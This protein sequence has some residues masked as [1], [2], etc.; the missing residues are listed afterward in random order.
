M[1]ACV[2]VRVFMERD[3]CDCEAERERE[4][5]TSVCIH[6][7]TAPA[8]SG[9][10]LVVLNAVCVSVQEGAYLKHSLSERR[11]LKRRLLIWSL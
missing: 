5:E 2:S 11:G 4:R 7:I 10:R 6:I 1:Y 9:A 3:T 8:V